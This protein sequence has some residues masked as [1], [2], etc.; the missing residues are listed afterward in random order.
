MKFRIFLILSLWWPMVGI[1]QCGTVISSFP[2]DEGFETSA[3]WTTGGTSSDWTRGTPAHPTINTAGGGSKSWMVGGLTGSSYNNGELAWLRSPCFDFTT[4]N[5]PWISFKIFWESEWMHDGMVLQYS[6]NGGTSWTNVGA[7]NDPV[8]C[9]NANWYNYDNVTYLTSASPKHGWAGRIG[10]TSGNCQGLHGSGAW[11]TAKHCM[12]NLAGQPSVR[13][14]FLFGAGTTCNS[15]DG[16]AI[17][18]IHIGNAP[19]NVASFTSACT[20]PNTISFTS[21]PTLCPTNYVWNFGDPASGIANTS[22][23][24][25]PSHVFTN[26]GSHT[27]MLTIIGPCNA[28]GS[29]SIPVTTLSLTT[30]VSNTNC[31]NTSGGS[32][33]ADVGSTPGN[34][35][36][37]WNPGGATTATVNGLSAGTYTVTASLSN[38][39]AATATAIITQSGAPIANFTENPPLTSA[40]GVPVQFNDISSLSTGNIINWSWNFGDG[41]PIVQGSD[42]AIYQNPIHNYTNSGNYQV[43]LAVESNNGCWDTIIYEYTVMPEIQIPNIFTPGQSGGNEVN[44]YFYIKNLEFVPNASLIIYNRW[45]EK[46]FEQKDYSSFEKTN[47]GWNGGK[48]SDGVYY[49]VISAPMFK[50]PKYGFVQLLRN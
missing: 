50:E 33:T 16:I 17:D 7:Y 15:F 8:D 23:L 31:G 20:G 4:L 3:A 27:V 42:P 14:R 12:T 24:A 46:V 28:S 32:A 34:V 43:V 22:T 25:N 18:D 10:T 1:S 39:C 30:T 45:G 47:I 13:F 41:S 44:Q 37:S 40:P 6:L 9:L 21:V 38:G 2:Y 35:S 11:V 36:Y 5:Y 19:A 29:V 48:C 49:Y 26:A